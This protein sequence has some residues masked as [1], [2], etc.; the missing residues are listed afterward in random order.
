[1]SDREPLFTTVGALFVLVAGDSGVASQ[2]IA[3]LS[4]ELETRIAAIPRNYTAMRCW[5]TGFYHTIATVTT[6]VLA[7]YSF[8]IGV[9]TELVDAGDFPDV[10]S[11]RGNWMLH[12]VRRLT[13]TAGG[14]AGIFTEL[15]PRH[16]GNEAGSAVH[17]TTRAAR[18]LA[19][20]D[21]KLFFVVQKD[22][23]TED[24]VQLSVSITTMWLLP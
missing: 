13:E 8:G 11:H 20:T 10:S 1:M 17:V 16:T 12:D 24:N 9:F 14:S 5:V 19:R 23:V 15:N 3:D 7:E 21:A 22:R 4:D 6:P 18:K 2:E